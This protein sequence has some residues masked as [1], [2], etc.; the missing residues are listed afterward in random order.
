MF[1]FQFLVG[2]IFFLTAPDMHVA[3]LSTFRDEI[4]HDFKRRKENNTYVIP[5]GSLLLSL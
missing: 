5:Q 1:R 4:I 3:I 2:A